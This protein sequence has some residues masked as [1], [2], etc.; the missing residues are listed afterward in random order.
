MHWSLLYD[1][2]VRSF[3]LRKLVAFI[4]L[5]L[6]W[7]R[8]AIHVIDMFAFIEIAVYYVNVRHLTSEFSLLPS[9]YTVTDKSK[10]YLNCAPK[11]G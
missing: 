6:V 2:V 1:C 7:M 11:S 3:A 8:N 9:Q 10:F 4:H 5:G